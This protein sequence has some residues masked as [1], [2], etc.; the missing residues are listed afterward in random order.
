SSVVDRHLSP[1]G[2]LIAAPVEDI[3]SDLGAQRR[4]RLAIIQDRFQLQDGAPRQGVELLADRS[5]SVKMAAFQLTAKPLQL[6]P[7]GRRPGD[8]ADHALAHTDETGDVPK[9]AA[10]EV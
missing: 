6:N 8:V 10:F 1:I 4:W 5:L 7:V 9:R 2:R 3:H